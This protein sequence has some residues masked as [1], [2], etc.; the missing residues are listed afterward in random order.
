MSKEWNLCLFLM[1]FPIWANGLL[2][3]EQWYAVS[4]DGT[5]DETSMEDT[6]RLQ[7]ILR[8]QRR[9]TSAVTEGSQLF[10]GR[11]K[12]QVDLSGDFAVDDR[13]RVS[14]SSDIDVQTRLDPSCGSGR[15][16]SRVNPD[17]PSTDSPSYVLNSVLF[18]Q[19]KK[20]LPH[21]PERCAAFLIGP[22][23]AVTAAHCLYNRTVYKWLIDVK[24]D[25][26]PKIWTGKSCSKEGTALPWLKMY[27]K[28]CFVFPN[29]PQCGTNDPEAYDYA[30]ILLDPRQHI[31]RQWL[32]FGYWHPRPA[33]QLTVHGYPSDK[34]C[35][36]DSVAG[37]VYAPMYRS[38]CKYT[39]AYVSSEGRKLHYR[40]DTV[41]GQSGSP[42]MAYDNTNT[43]LVAYGVHAHGT[44]SCSSGSTGKGNN[45]GTM[46]NFER[47]WELVEWIRATGYA[48]KTRYPKGQ[49]PKGRWVTQPDPSCSQTTD[50]NRTA[51]WKERC[52]TNL[53]RRTFLVYLMNE[54]AW[55]DILSYSFLHLSV[56]VYVYT[57]VQ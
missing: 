5:V 51:K 52:R 3:S 7:A 35:V 28:R 48:M 21:T 34:V 40:C 2:S 38:S 57:A 37:T 42:V 43:I 32:P 14:N 41:K 13:V 20:G 49:P 4:S 47:F 44:Q 6:L 33:N 17:T 25:R 46:I 29:G 24:G 15:P 31:S 19:H 10:E 36:R 27:V 8:K 45:K 55:N 30:Y 9:H 39:C 11:R 1:V 53:H 18:L 54:F 23:H 16:S 50:W 26:Y 56:Y 12:R 22:Y